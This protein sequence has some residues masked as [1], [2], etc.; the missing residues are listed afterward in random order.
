ML[1]WL[2][3]FFYFIV[4]SMIGWVGEVCYAYVVHHR[5]VNRGFLNGPLCP[6]YGV[7]ALLFVAIG[8]V[9]GHKPGMIFIASAV[10]ATAL[11]YITGYLLEKIFHRRYWDYSHSKF[12]IN[13]YV[14]LVATLVWGAAGVLA[15]M[16]IHPFV[17]SVVGKISV[18]WRQGLSWVFLVLF[19][20]DLWTTI[21]QNIHLTK[22]LEE[23]RVLSEKLADTRQQENERKKL[24]K[25]Y[26]AKLAAQGFGERRILGAF[27]GLNSKRHGEAVLSIRQIQA[28]ISERLKKEKEKYRQGIHELK[29]NYA[30][31]Q[32]ENNHMEDQEKKNK[33][34]YRKQKRALKQRY[35]Q[36][37]DEIKKRI[38]NK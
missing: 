19:L 16:W 25:E 29:E 18:R 12:N 17:L 1:D 13:G 30:R 5:F 21:A 4:Y 22:R 38:W 24:E 35:E 2:T 7:G 28:S 6:M 31:W 34:Q 27:P 23:L 10:A 37:Q 8:Q 32:R 11:E 26:N 20:A 15:V 36:I 9:L 33:Q 3:L 14:T